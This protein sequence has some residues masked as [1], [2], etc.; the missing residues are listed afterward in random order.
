LPCLGFGVSLAAST[1]S[2]LTRSATPRPC[3]EPRGPSP[4]A[5]DP[6][7]EPAAA[8]PAG[9]EVWVVTRV[10]VTVCV[11][12]VVEPRRT[13]VLPAREPLFAPPEGVESTTAENGA[14]PPRPPAVRAEGTVCG[15]AIAAPAK[16]SETPRSAKGPEP[17]REQR[18]FS[19]ATAISSARHD[20]I[21]EGSGMK[22][23]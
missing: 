7:A 13:L 5:D 22:P 2:P 8:T 21:R 14:L 12:T 20:G 23:G 15:P 11:E 3:G 10:R 9:F 16:S 4:A 17:M 18:F 6:E 19:V 1:S